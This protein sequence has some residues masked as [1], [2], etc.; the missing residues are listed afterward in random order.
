MGFEPTR[1]LT[2]YTISNRAPSTNSDITPRKERLTSYRLLRRLTI[3]RILAFMRTTLS[4]A[5]LLALAYPA[6]AQ[7]GLLDHS[8]AEFFSHN[9]NILFLAGGLLSTKQ[10]LKSTEA[11]VTAVGISQALKLL[12]RERRPDG[13]S[14]DSFPSGHATAAFAVAALASQHKGRSEAALWYVGATLIGDSRV[15]LRRHYVHDVVA[16]AALGIAVVRTPGLRVS[17]LLPRRVQ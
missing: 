11:M 17:L 16:G 3:H 9:G 2:A 10:P 12:S 4:L 7:T 8:R 6:H 14:L 15:S 13:T 1:P 5:A